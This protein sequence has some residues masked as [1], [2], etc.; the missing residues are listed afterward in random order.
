ML[1]LLNVLQSVL[2][3][4]EAG[5]DAVQ[6][7]LDRRLE[8]RLHRRLQQPI[9]GEVQATNHTRGSSDQKQHGGRGNKT[10]NH[11]V[12][13]FVFFSVSDTGQALS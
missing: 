5:A 6:L 3:L 4:V 1:N 8:L 13:Y 7:R 9:R 10:E 11:C 12:N 2:E